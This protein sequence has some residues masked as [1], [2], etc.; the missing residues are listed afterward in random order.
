[1]KKAQCWELDIMLNR[2][3]N[4]LSFLPLTTHLLPFCGFFSYM[5]MFSEKLQHSMF[6]VK[7]DYLPHN[8]RPI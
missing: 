7:A 5:K 8:I 6:G 3:G 1:M 4:Q 2:G